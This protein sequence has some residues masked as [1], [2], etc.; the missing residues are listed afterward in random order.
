VNERDPIAA[1]EAAI[2]AC[3]SLSGDA[4]PVERMLVLLA[5]ERARARAEAFEEAAKVITTQAIRWKPNA[6]CHSCAAR[7]RALV[8]R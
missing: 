7:I 5:A 8:S 2:R 1:D 4:S 6:S 3:L